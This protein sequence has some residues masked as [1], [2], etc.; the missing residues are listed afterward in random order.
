[1][2]VLITSKTAWGSRFCIGGLELATGRYVR[3]MTTIGTYQPMNSPFQIGEIWNLEYN[4]RPDQPPHVEDVRIIRRIGLIRKVNNMY[5]FITQNCTVWN[6]SYNVLFG[7]RL[8]WNGSGYINDPNNLPANS[9]GFWISDQDL[10]WDG[11]YYVYRRPRLKTNKRIKYKGIQQP[12]P[13]IP[14]GTLIRVSLAKWW[15]GQGGE[16]RCYLQ[17]S[18]WY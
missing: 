2:E 15:D 10:Y 1:M 9:V 14:A 5:N 7:G 3:L 11:E 6:G 18:G 17:L 12:I 16:N 13:V 4:Y 8:R